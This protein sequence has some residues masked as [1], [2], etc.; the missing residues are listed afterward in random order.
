MGLL[1]ESKS[2][3]LQH[4]KKKNNTW[5]RGRAEKR[6]ERLSVGHH[7]NPGERW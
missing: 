3:N 5:G 4:L 1:C 6:A 7:S 2:H